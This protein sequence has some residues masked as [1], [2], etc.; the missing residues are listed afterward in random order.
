MD[1]NS[2]KLYE[3]AKTYYKKCTT[4]VDEI[5]NNENSLRQFELKQF[6]T[7]ALI[8]IQ[9]CAY[10]DRFYLTLW[11]DLFCRKLEQYSPIY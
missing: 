2:E 5:R 4:D 3:F 1:E 7:D 10:E 8:Y 6:Y 9:P 11:K